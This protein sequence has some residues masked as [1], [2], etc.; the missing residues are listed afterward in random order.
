MVELCYVF[1]EVTWRGKPQHCVRILTIEG[2]YI[3][4]YIYPIELYTNIPWYTYFIYLI[5]IHLQCYH[6]R[7]SP[8]SILAILFAH[9]FPYY[10]MSYVRLAPHIIV[11]LWISPVVP[12]IHGWTWKSSD[13]SGT[14]AYYILLPGF[15]MMPMWYPHTIST[16]FL[17][18]K[19]QY[20]GFWSTMSYCFHCPHI[21]DC[22]VVWNMNGLFFHSVGNSTPNW[23]T[24]FF[25]GVGWKHQP[26][27]QAN[28]WGISVPKRWP[29]NHGCLQDPHEICTTI[30]HISWWS[31]RV[32]FQHVSPW[33]IH[34]WYSHYK[35]L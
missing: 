1:F 9:V 34:A 14:Y 15:P 19:L 16:I 11:L 12:S 6:D 3:Y 2:W 8:K 32:V 26:D 10:H 13:S 28:Q 7:I 22:L 21:C 5:I 30:P 20:L 35:S 31:K 25:R 23:R 17:L 4:I 33:A 27:D 18:E 24:P 29:S